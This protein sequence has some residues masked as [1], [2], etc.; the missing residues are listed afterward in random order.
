M[1]VMAG[2]AGTGPAARAADY[3]ADP[4]QGRAENPGTASAP[5]R[6]LAEVVSSGQI[7]QLKGGDTLWLR[8]GF[9]GEVT[10]SGNFPETVTVCA[11]EGA[12]P[13]VS[14]LNVTG[15]RWHVRGLTVSPSLGAGETPKGR[16]TLVVV[17]ESG[18]AEDV[19]IENCFVYSVLDAGRW[20]ARQWMEAPSGML[21]G[22]NG[23]RL[24]FR[25]NYILNTRFGLTMSSFDSQ[26]EGNIIENFSADGMR[27]TRDGETAEHNI[28]RNIY[29]SA[30]DGDQNHD[31]GIQGFL[32]NVGHGLI[33]RFTLRE[34]IIVMREDESQPFKASLQGIGMFDGPLE[35]FVVEGNVICTQHWH[36][37]SLFDATNSVIRDNVVFNKWGGRMNP[38]IQLG[39]KNR[40]GNRGNIVSNNY[41][42][43]F[44]L[45]E[46]TTVQAERNRP[47]TRA[48]WERRQAE[49]LKKIEEK[50]GAVHPVARR[51]RLRK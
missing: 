51:P 24:T 37:I 48:V 8:D 12:R 4:M 16:A 44:R 9:H 21:M 6:T 31:D 27:M 42:H 41:A 22:R 40:G 20:T 34:N 2:L 47:V 17:G 25:N 45:G 18:P 3:F 39:S 28:I 5:W 10:L 23:R 11:A 33:R 26:A 49:L 29:V 30:E 15:S 43:S 13:G 35:E 50:Y 32:F 7:Q 14:R 1:L 36:G 19:L 46:E 38:W